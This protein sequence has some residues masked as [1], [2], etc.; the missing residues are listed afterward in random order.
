M[1]HYFIGIA[2]IFCLG[3]LCPAQETKAPFNLE[4]SRQ[5]LE[6]MKGILETSLS[7]SLSD[8]DALIS[9]F[10]VSNIDAFY[11][12]G[13]GAVFMVPASNLHVPGGFIITPEFSEQMSALK[14]KYAA[15]SKQLASQAEKL[16]ST[17]QELN[18]NKSGALASPQPP[19]PPKL[20]APPQPP[21]P[22]IVPAPQ[23]AEQK[24]AAEAR[25]AEYQENL[26]KARRGLIETLANYGDS[27]TT[28]Q[29]DEFINLILT[30]GDYASGFYRKGSGHQ[31]TYEVI[32]A[33]KSWITDYKAGRLSLEGFKEKILQYSN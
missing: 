24:E 3:I 21:A 12:S 22:V 9:G 8:A 31:A 2:L 17:A 7:Y 33:R 4:K 5:E 11:L 32:T 19:A 1:K 28:V 15:L 25:K 10:R 29:S 20:P 30:T 27:L 23:T 6:I 16:A 26:E 14:E 18:Q 13:Q